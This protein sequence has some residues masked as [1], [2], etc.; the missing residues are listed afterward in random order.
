[1]IAA[2]PRVPR[3]HG[4]SLDR[5]LL[6]ALPLVEGAGVAVYDRS[7]N[8][9]AVAWGSSGVVWQRGDYG[10][11]LDFDAT[12]G[13]VLNL[14]KPGLSEGLPEFTTS[15]WVRVDSAANNQYIAAEY[16]NNNVSQSFLLR[17]NAS[18]TRWNFVLRDDTLTQ[19]SALAANGSMSAG[20]WTHVV[21]RADI[22]NGD[23]AIYV[24]GVREGE[25]LWGGSSTISAGGGLRFDSVI[26]AYSQ[27][28]SGNNALD[29]QLA[30]V[31]YWSRALTDSEIRS[32]YADPWAQYRAP[33]VYGWL[34]PAAAGG[35][36]LIGGRLVNRS[37]LFGGR[38]IA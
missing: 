33:M 20:V 29:G 15:G 1:M 10:A 18:N 27:A 22:P 26:G 23:V 8:R 17:G 6:L 34:P 35:G 14:G 11:Q 19:R 21:G 3:L 4:H 13:A 9:H 36:T 7:P 25:V 5:G 28:S 16:G 31:R 24:N 30:D 2:K 37:R 38:L 12:S 32:L